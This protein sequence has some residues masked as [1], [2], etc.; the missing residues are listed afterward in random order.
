MNRNTM[1]SSTLLVICGFALTVAAQNGVAPA[2]KPAASVDA[3]MHGQQDQLKAISDL[4]AN[5]TAK[6]RGKNIAVAAELLAELANVNAYN[7][8]KADYQAWA[9]DLRDTSLTLSKD[10]R[11][12][13]VKDEDLKKAVDRIKTICQAC[14]DVH[15]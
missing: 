10:A 11:K 2:F 5:K 7:K 8:D 1:I 4:V 14:H 6:D 12:P 13:D 15:R 9:R 3:L